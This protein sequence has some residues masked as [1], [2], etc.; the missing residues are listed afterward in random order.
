[1]PDPTAGARI[2]C[3]KTVDTIRI[4]SCERPDSR[5]EHATAGLGSFE[6][7]TMLIPL[8]CAV[9]TCVNSEV[10]AYKGTDALET[11]VFVSEEKQVGYC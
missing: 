8:C 7:Q 6:V 1:M 3:A 5:T 4:N 10:H 2:E 9:A 11:P